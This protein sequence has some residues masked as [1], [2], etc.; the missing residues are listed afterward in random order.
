[1]VKHLAQHRSGLRHLWWLVALLVLLMASYVVAA[2]QLMSMLPEWRAPLQTL[3]Q[4]RTGLPLSIGALTGRMEGLTPVLQLDE[5]VVP[6]ADGDPQHALTIKQVSVALDVLMSLLHRSVWLRDLSLSGLSLDI[7][8]DKDGHFQLRGFPRKP[9]PAS[10]QASLQSLLQLLYQQKQVILDQVNLSLKLNGM[11]LMT[12]Q[13]AHLEMVSSGSHHQLALHLQTQQQPLTLDLRLD[14]KADAFDIGDLTGAAYVGLAGQNMEY[15]LPKSLTQRLPVKKLSGR[16]AFWLALDKGQLAQSTLS[17]Q[18]QQLVLAEDDKQWQV[19]QLHGLL[20]AR[21]QDDGYQVQVQG[22][23]FDT[24]GGHWHSGTLG[25][26]W[27][28][29]QGADAGWKLRLTDLDM[30]QLG[31]QLLHW[32]FALPPQ[33]LKLRDKLTQLRPQAQLAAFYA[34]GSGHEVTRFAGRFYQASIDAVGKIPGLSGITG[35]FDGSP[36]AGSAVIDSSRL[37][38]NLPL[39]Y[40]HPLTLSAA[41]E[42]RWFHGE[43]GLLRL[44]TGRWH[45]SNPDGDAQLVAGVTLVP[46]KVPLLHLLAHLTGQHI[47]RA[48]AYIPTRKLPPSLS[49]WLTQAIVGGQL[50][51]G[52]FLYEGPVHIDK[53]RQ[54]DRTLQMQFAVHNAELA[55]LPG[56]PSLQHLSGRVLMDGRRVHGRDLSGRIYDSAFSHTNFDVWNDDPGAVPMLLVSGKV[57]A[58]AQDLGKLLHDSPLAAKLPQELADWQLTNGLIDGNLLL[59]LALKKGADVPPQVVVQAAATDLSLANSAR[60]IA[61]DQVAG[62]VHFDLQRG[63][64]AQRLHANWLGSPLIGNISTAQGKLAIA[65]NGKLDVTQLATWLKADWLQVASGK[66]AAQLALT[67]PWLSQQPVV[68][69]VTSDLKGVAIDLPA[70]LAKPAATAAPL[71]LTLTAGKRLDVEYNGQPRVSGSL[72]L[73]AGTLSG[74]TLRLGPGKASKAHANGLLIEGSLPQLAAQPWLDFVSKPAAVAG[75]KPSTLPL[76]HLAL[77]LGKLDLNGFVVKHAKFELAPAKPAGWQLQ[78][79][80]RQLTASLMV[81]AAYQLRGEKPLVLKV[82][83]L[84]WPALSAKTQAASAELAPTDLPVADVTLANLHI[85]AENLGSWQGQIRPLANGVRVQQLKGQWRHAR[86][87]GTLD[88]TQHQGQQSSHYAGSVTSND[89][90]A[91]QKEWGIRPVIESDKA[92]ASVNLSWPGTPLALDYLHLNGSAQFEVGACRLPHMDSNNPLLRLLGA[93]NVNSIAR[94]LRFDFS[95]LYKKGLSCDSIDAKFAFDQAKLTVEKLRLK[96]P[97]A[98]ITLSG[99]TNLKTHQLDNDMTVVLPLSSNLYAGCIAGPAACAGIFVFDRLLGHRL[100]K[101]AALH[102]QVSGDWSAPVIKEK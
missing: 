50:T 31:G 19:Q 56:W 13:D 24:S 59:Q 74:G 53:K 62:S 58:Q 55:F 17:L 21:A 75:T 86:F 18:V 44:E 52:Q 80:S 1:M 77:Q 29:K 32:P 35:W 93:L 3:L 11:P 87:D 51:Q 23:D 8:Q 42:L 22:L 96:S 33:L 30:Q 34:A 5:L 69:N 92:S 72:I 99:H 63:V 78:L 41:G 66:T 61:L 9:Q 4:Q 26:W 101:A 6:A 84:H 15:W 49:T 37:G 81:P 47:E 76:S 25:G 102:Y 10:H 71:A 95:D 27:N 73:D 38:L 100:E 45:L 48:D 7:A 90:G 98:D 54:Q 94:R 36:D 46:G 89:L 16:L 40:D 2:R 97:S 20:A 85:G 43:A 12:T 91:L 83:Q 14:L 28:G 65:A 70:P 57:A 67:L 60:R 68:L 82:E 88:W 39:L 79:A 64:E